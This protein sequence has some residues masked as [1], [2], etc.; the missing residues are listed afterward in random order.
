MNVADYIVNRLVEFG[1]TDVFGLPGGVVLD[2]LY[3]VDKRNNNIKV[4]LCYHEQS[5]GFAA[6]GYGKISNKLGVVYVTRGPGFTNVI[7]AIADAYYDSVPMLVITAHGQKECNYNMRCEFNQEMDI[8]ALSRNITK[9]SIRINELRDIKREV[10]KAIYIA[11]TGRQGPVVIDIFTELLKKTIDET[12]DFKKVFDDSLNYSSIDDICN[13]LLKL[14]QIHYKPILLIGDG[15]NKTLSHNNLINIVN[16]LNIPVLSSRYAQHL[17]PEHKLYFGYIGSHGLRYSNFIL[18]KTDL[19]IAIGNRLSYPI[20]SE[21]FKPITFN[22]PKIRIDIDENEIR[23]YI[24]NCN[25][26]IMDINTLLPYLLKKININKCYDNWIK[27]CAYIKKN[28]E[29]YDMLYPVKV[30]A[31]LIQAAIN[32]ETLT[33]DVGNHEFW[34][35]RA[36]ASVGISKNVVYSKSFGALGSS[37]GKA[38]GAYYADKKPVICFAGDQGIQLN[39]QEL[40]YIGQHK[41]P[42]IIVVFNNMSSGMIKSREKIKKYPYFLHTT[43]DSGYANPNFEFIASA[44]GI[45]YYLFNNNEDYVLHLLNNIVKPIFIELKIDEDIELVPFLPVGNSCQNLEPELDIEL[46]KEIDEI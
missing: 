30:A 44:Y 40:Q 26:Y 36:Y 37:I 45:E 1:V 28:L 7:T 46:F 19:I 33:C 27:D 23:R 20:K 35:S 4:H 8:I 16:K 17:M 11:T 25:S 29:E 2:F 43:V 21:S 5:A 38:I 14:L 24:P 41:L 13:N 22:I 34:V 32:V 18:S 12:R 6:Y 10:E 39:I 15:I 3:A 9:Y 31:R 42:I